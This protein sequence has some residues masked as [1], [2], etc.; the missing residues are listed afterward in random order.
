MPFFLNFIGDRFGNLS[1]PVQARLEENFHRDRPVN[2]HA[3]CVSIGTS[4]S[5]R[6]TSRARRRSRAS[7]ST[8]V[9]GLLGS[10]PCRPNCALIQE[11]NSTT[12]GLACV[13][14]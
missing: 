8:F 14:R 11:K 3:E 1:N 4:G 9:S 13:S 5:F 10:S 6:K 2:V 12:I 7:A